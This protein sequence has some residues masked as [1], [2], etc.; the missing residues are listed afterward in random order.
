M[1]QVPPGLRRFPSS[2]TERVRARMSDR[3]T[4]IAHYAAAL[5]NR[6]LP[7][8]HHLWLGPDFPADY[9]RKPDTFFRAKPDGELFIKFTEGLQNT[10]GAPAFANLG[11]HRAEPCHCQVGLNSEGFPNRPDWQA[12]SV[13]VHKLLHA[14]GL[15]AHVPV[16]TCP[17]SSMSNTWFRLDGSLPVIDAAAPQVLYLRLGAFTPPED[18]SPTM[19]GAWE[20]ESIDTRAILD[21]SP[22]AYVMRTA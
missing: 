18:L 12:V 21:P 17:D 3:E 9:A 5:I 7:Y 1:Y 10:D 13:V 11:R 14:L 2:P 4:A 15:D 8:E 19:L 22:S 20:D 16:D 6:T